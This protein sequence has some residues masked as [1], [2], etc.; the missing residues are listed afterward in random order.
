MFISI[1]P[2]LVVIVYS[3]GVLRRALV[4]EAH[5]K[6]LMIVLGLAAEHERTVESTRRLLTSLAKMEDI[7]NKEVSRCNRILGNAPAENPIYANLFLATPEG[8][9]FSS[10]MPFTPP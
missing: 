5:E 4:R 1:L 6:A 9:V 2:A 10:A 3:E 7:Q 8:T